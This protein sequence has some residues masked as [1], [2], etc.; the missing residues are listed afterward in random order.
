MIGYFRAYW[1]R[2]RFWVEM[3]IIALVHTSLMWL[4]FAYL[5]RNRFDIPLVFCIPGILMECWLIF[6]VVTRTRSWLV[7]IAPNPAQ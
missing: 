3:G 7:G 2:S 6:I 5:L 1:K 4:V